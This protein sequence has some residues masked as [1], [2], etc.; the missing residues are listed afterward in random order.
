MEKTLRHN[1][2]PR[3]LW[4]LVFA[5][6]S[7][8]VMSVVPWRQGVLYGGGVDPV[9]LAKAAIG[10]LAFGSAMALYLTARV[11]SRVGMRSLSLLSLIVSIALLGAFANGSSVAAVVLSVRIALIAATVVLIVASVPPRV[12]LMTLLAAL[13]VVAAAAAI[14]GAAKGLSLGR[15]GGGIP[16]MAPNVL[17]G[18]AAAPAIGLAADIAGRGVR[19]WNLAA[20]AAMFAIVFATQSRTT[21]IVLVLGVVLAFLCTP[22]LTTSAAM[23]TIAALPF[24]YLLLAFTDI[25]PRILGRGQSV[26]ELSTFSSRT[27]AWDAVLATPFDSWAKWIGVGLAAKTVPVQ[28]RWRDEQVL[29]SSWVS[30]IAQ[31]GLIGTALLGIWIVFS[32][33]ESLRRSSL[34]PIA[35]PLLVTLLIRS[36]TESGLVDSSATFLI[37]LTVSLLLEPGTRVPH[38]AMLPAPYQLA[39]PLPIAKRDRAIPTPATSPQQP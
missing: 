19:L 30:V 38:E 34:K 13:G 29:D 10:T 36:F 11:H 9:V 28:Q 32:T 18:L 23:L 16:D 4:I 25:V 31:A 3:G 8:L 14:T 26:Q 17:A 37:F 20:F 12:V 24:S 33:V 7:V 22:R 6:Q 27:V 5:I 15:L 35:L 1:L 39:A 2:S 21:L